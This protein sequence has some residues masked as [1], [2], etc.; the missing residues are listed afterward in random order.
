MGCKK[1]NP[2]NLKIWIEFF[3]KKI[4]RNVKDYGIWTSIKKSTKFLIWPFYHK[5]TYIIYEL[6][7]QD[8]PNKEININEY[9]FKILTVEDND[10]INQI[11]NT[12]EWLK[13][14]LKKSLSRNGICIAI[15]RDDK[16]AGF[17]WVTLGVGTIPLLKLRI[18][19]KPDESWSE[20]ITIFKDFRKK[21]L[22]NQLRTEFYHE[23]KKMGIKALYGHRQV[24]NIASKMS[25]QKYTYRKL[26]KADY[27]KI[28][29]IQRFRYAKFT[30]DQ[31]S[32]ELFQGGV[33]RTKNM[34]YYYI[35]PKKK[36]EYLFTCDISDLK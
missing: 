11:E 25:A 4:F 19:I 23:L 14:E 9:R 35:E 36:E 12:E 24:W 27:I 21:G 31:S 2:D 8:I 32:E 13:G 7:L 34:K 18:I 15:L 26:V 17:N 1:K 6:N 20:Q 10:F 28:L 3:K 30:S 22:A 33:T 29:N 5:I 16:V